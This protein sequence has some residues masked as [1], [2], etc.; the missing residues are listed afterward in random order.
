VSG[1]LHE[2]SQ[3]IGALESRA[4]TSERDMAEMKRDVKMIL[5]CL[6]QAKGGW[7]TLLLVAGMASAVGALIGKLLPFASIGK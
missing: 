7:K 4:E 3:A 6:A 5:G 1:E 2:I